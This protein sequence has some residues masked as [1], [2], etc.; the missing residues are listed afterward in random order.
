MQGEVAEMRRDMAALHEE[1]KLL[2]N[3]VDHLKHKLATGQRVLSNQQSGA[4][5]RAA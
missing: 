2:R 1:V 4:T 5:V 3:E